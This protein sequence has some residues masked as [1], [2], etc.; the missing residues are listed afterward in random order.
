MT[1][2]LTDVSRSEALRDSRFMIRPTARNRRVSHIWG[3]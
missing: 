3:G 2:R 1:P